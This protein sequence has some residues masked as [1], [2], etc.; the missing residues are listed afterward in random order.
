MGGE[1]ILS[2]QVAS[3]FIASHYLIMKN[4]AF[5]MDQYGRMEF[6]PR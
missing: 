2:R 1:L 3:C 6:T 4:P 5:G